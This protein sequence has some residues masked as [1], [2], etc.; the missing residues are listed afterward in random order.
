MILASSW[1]FNLENYAAVWNLMVQLGILLIGL[2]LGNLLRN[3]V[4][5]LRKGLVPSALIGGL[6]ILIVHFI[7]K[8][9]G[10]EWFGVV[11]LVDQQ[12]MQVVTYH[13]LGIGFVAMSLK[14]VKTKNKLPTR[15][16]IENGAMTGGAY[17]IQAFLGLGITIIMFLIASNNFFGIGLLLPLG[18][19]QGPGNAL[20][21]DINFTALDAYD[22]TGGGSVGL[23][24][25]SVGFIVASVIGVIYINIFR[26]KGQINVEERRAVQRTIDVYEGENEIPDTESVD[27]LSVQLM[28]VA[29]A[30]ALAF[31]I[32]VIFAKISD[33]TNGIA[34]G[35]NFIWGVITANLV[36]LVLKFFRKK[37]IVKR[38]YINNYQMDRI[39][40]FAFDLMI[41][42]G[43][44]A[45]EIEQVKKYIVPIVILCVV[46]TIATYLYVRLISRH[47]FKGYE[48]EMFVTN[49]GTVTGTASNGM[50]LLKEIDPNYDS[51]ASNLFILSQLPAM[52]FV[53]PLLLLLNFAVKDLTHALIA[54][55]IFFLLFIGYTVFLII[56]GK[57]P[58]KVKGD[59]T[60]NNV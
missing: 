14:T 45:I 52:I 43:V 27:K 58:P 53:A 46:G 44:A 21:W 50:I 51:P 7:M 24:I 6:L 19:G 17:M 29:I 49:F 4:P 23:T 20:A 18:F 8:K 41:V 32:M 11:G 40:G 37:N 38:D 39:S 2:F 34:W 15:K 48:H 33:F 1:S 12:V 47:C 22:Y 54:C 42:A 25:A 9:C 60:A 13:G 10:V 59:A 57:R 30:Y 5:F 35:F 56:S 36:K 16:V 55:G 26:R 28:F 31:G 3:V